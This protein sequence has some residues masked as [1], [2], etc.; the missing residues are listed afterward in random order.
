MQAKTSSFSHL[1][2]FLPYYRKYW[3]ILLL[4]LFCALLTTLCELVFPRIVSYITDQ[5]IADASVVTLQFV[6]RPA[7]L[8]LAL[9]VI[10]GGAFYYM[11]SMGHVMGARI[12]TDMRSELFSH[13]QQ[14]SFSFYSN[15][16]IGQLMSRMTSDLF[17]VTEFAHH[18]PEEFTIALIKIV[19]TFV[20]LLG[21][22]FPLTLLIFALLPVLL[23][24][25]Y[26]FNKRMRK[27]FAD[28]RYQLGEINAQTE[29]SLLGMRVVQSF[30][31][32]ELESEKF[33]RGN[34]TFLKLKGKQYRVMAGFHITTRMLHGFM[35]LV[36]V[37]G[38]ALLLAQGKITAG[39]YLSYLLYVNLL[40]ASVQKLIQFTE[41]YQR[42]ITGIER[43]YE[44]M[45]A[46]LEIKDGPQAKA[47]KGVAG[48]IRFDRVSFSYGGE[49]GT[50]VLS[51]VSLTVEPGQSVALVGPSG[52]GKTT[53]CNLIPRFYDVTGGSVLV[54]GQDVRGLKLKSLRGAIGMVQQDVY[55]FSGTIFDNIAYGKPGASLE[56]VVEAARRAGAHEFI[57]A[58]PDGY[59]SFV[60]ERGMKLSG[61]QK[62][63]ISIA[64][65][66]L[67]DPPILLLDEATSALD[68][69]SERL[70]QQSLEELSRGRTTLTIAH[71]L[72]TIRNAD[73]I[74][75]LTEKGLEEHGSH[76]ELIRRG[77]IYSSLYQLYA[78]GGQ[79]LIDITEDEA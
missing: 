6:L 77:G 50:E 32:E 13:L 58:L 26:S 79:D 23:V 63:R 43:F 65:V 14:L 78:A 11:Q 66:F 20:I 40:L 24:A 69:E 70:V 76:E 28:C 15:A 27:A 59:D 75:V 57:S 53:M 61:G 64:R 54:D 1:R 21:V 56:E 30:T 68:N 72:S 31:N 46:P 73:L 44:V 48:E 5:A 33:D 45:D 22:N 17:E 39:D 62:Q 38:G 47:L 74:W 35:N 41:L 49:G 2:R 12:E 36:V 42:G 60:G 7:L 10:D 4:D 52:S 16:K 19:A 8:Y 37:V 25:T 18:C 55:L 67:K 29:D 51:E 3:P 34:Q 71:R 9:R